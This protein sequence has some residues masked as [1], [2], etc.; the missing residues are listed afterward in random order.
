MYGEETLLAERVR[1]VNV[2]ILFDAY[3]RVMHEEHSTVK[4]LPSK[5]LW[6]IKKKASERYID[7]MWHIWRRGK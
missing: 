2:R 1:K 3:L 5:E 7:F 6:K 4:L